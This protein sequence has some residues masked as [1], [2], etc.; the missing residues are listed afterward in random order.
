MLAGIS[1]VPVRHDQLTTW[2]QKAQ[3]LIGK[4]LLVGNVGRRFH[5]PDRVE[6]TVRN[7]HGQRVH[8]VEAAGDMCRCQC[9]GPVNLLAA[10]ADAQHLEAVISGQNPCAAPN[11]TTHV[12][13]ATAWRQLVKTGPVNH[14]MDQSR[15]AGP[16]I[17]GLGRITVV[18]QM[19]VISPKALQE[20]ITG[21]VVVIDGNTL[22]RPIGTLAG[23]IDTERQAQ[24]TA[25]Q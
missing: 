16:E 11:A 19:D 24:N 22:W 13:E 4:A 21:P 17:L 5:S 1:L 3:Q 12:Q 6:T 2:F 23:K 7:G 25:D 10:D 14:F 15:F 9:T 20:T 18:A 8:H